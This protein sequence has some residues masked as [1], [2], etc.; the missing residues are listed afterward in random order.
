MNVTAIP[1]GYA[2]EGLGFYF[3]PVN[4]NPKVI[5]EEKSATVRVLEGSI[6]AELLAVELE[7]LLPGK[8]KWVI[9]EK[10]KDAFTTNFPSSDLLDTMVYW[11]PM[12]TKTVKGKIQFEKSVEEDVYKYEIEKVWVQFRGLPKEFREF[13]IIWAIAS[14]LGVPRAVDTKFMKKFGRARMK[15]AVLDS[16]LIPVFVDVVIGDYVYQLHFGVEQGMPDGEPELIDLDSTMED[17]DPKGEKPNE[18]KTNGKM[19]IDGGKEGDHVPNNDAGNQ[20]PAAGAAADA[21][22]Q[23]A[24]G[25]DPMSSQ[26]KPVKDPNRPVIVLSQ[27]VNA[28]GDGQWKAKL[29]PPQIDSGNLNNLKAH[30]GGT[31]S[32]SRSSK[33][34][35]ATADQDSV[36]KATKLKTKR[37]MDTT[38]D[39][40]KEPQPCSF[41]S[42]DDSS[43]LNSATSIG[44]VLGDNEYEILNS[45][46]S[47]R[48]LEKFR[49]NQNKKLVDDN[50][51]VLDDASIVCS[52]DDGIDL[53]ALNFICSEISE[54][55][56][57]GGCDPKCLQTPVSRKKSPCR[58]KKKTKNHSR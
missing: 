15:V 2:V 43:L 37:N 55:L 47:L 30:K 10:G 4:E 54:G 50:N 40:G 5:V 57:D 35:A 9:E 17:D 48:D 56:G 28:N 16:N 23:Q 8:T 46:N 45:L 19:D 51:I 29:M 22:Q 34:T 20:L 1:C 18:D 53:E 7:N 33:R 31:V 27:N 42:R 21:T 3:I 25:A 11:G 6:T 38:P 58:H 24:K 41:I 12:V 13:P 14:I 49:L 36:D 26:G 44:V 52:N 39:K 32:P